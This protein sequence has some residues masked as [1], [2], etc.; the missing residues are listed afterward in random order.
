MSEE[1]QTF[2]ESSLLEEYLLGLTTPEDA[3]KVERMLET[4]ADVRA[5][6]ERM[7]RDVEQFCNTYSQAPPADL[8]DF[9]LGD[10]GA[11][12]APQM[13]QTEP[14]PSLVTPQP[15]PKPVMVPVQGGSNLNWMSAAAALAALIAV[16]AAVYLYNQNNELRTQL[17]ASMEQQETIARELASIRGS[18]QSQ[19][20]VQTVAYHPQ[21]ETVLLRG[22][23]KSPGLG[24]VAYW[25][26]ETEQ[27]FLNVLWLPDIPDKCYQLWADVHGEMINLG[28]LDPTQAPFAPIEFKVDAESLNITIE[29]IGG[30]DHPTVTDLVS[31]IQI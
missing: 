19:Q 15:D 29:P 30:S 20:T 16:A 4:D 6:Y 11:H 27:S 17:A 5:E 21:T 2:L 18:L 8:R 13:G 14:E 31:S 9:L 12:D 1:K 22:T 7:Q 24:V 10:L 25:N 28:V 26:R 3:A 23:D